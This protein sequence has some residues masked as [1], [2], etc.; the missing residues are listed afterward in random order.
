MEVTHCLVHKPHWAVITMGYHSHA[1][2]HLRATQACEEK[3]AVEV[4]GNCA[5]HRHGERVEGGPRSQHTHQQTLSDAQ[6]S[7]DIPCPVEMDGLTLTERTKNNRGPE[8]TNR[9]KAT[10]SSDCQLVTRN[11]DLNGIKYI[12]IKL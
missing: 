7:V 2:R 12:Y 10:H 8:N 4:V 6:F 11:T 1:V 5:I 3:G 9:I